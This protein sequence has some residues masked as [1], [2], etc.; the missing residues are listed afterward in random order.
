MVPWLTVVR[1][2][3]PRHRCLFGLLV[4][5]QTANERHGVRLLGRIAGRSN[6]C[7]SAQ[8]IS[9]DCFIDLDAIAVEEIGEQSRAGAFVAVTERVVF[10]DHVEKVCGLLLR[11]RVEILAH[12]C[13]VDLPDDTVNRVVFR[14]PE[15]LVVRVAT[16]EFLDDPL[17]VVDSDSFDSQG[18]S[19]DR[20]LTTVV[21]GKPVEVAGLALHD[22]SDA[23]Q[24]L[25][26]GGS[27]QLR[28][29]ACAAKC[30]R[31]LIQNPRPEDAGRP[32]A[33]AHALR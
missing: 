4:G 29:L 22:P 9:R 14:H 7:D 19:G 25:I 10:D 5:D 12:V 13:L 31:V 28:N 32:A 3:G 18:F 8:H 17:N 2:G 30:G 23:R 6:Q 21:I 20:E 26:S 33:E 11:P 27:E 1:R 16:A 15:P 24:L